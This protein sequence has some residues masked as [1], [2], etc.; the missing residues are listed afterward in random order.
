MDIL[1]YWAPSVSNLPFFCLF[2]LWK[3]SFW[4]QPFLYTSLP[5]LEKWSFNSCNRSSKVR[6]GSSSTE[7]LHLQVC[8]F[9][10][11]PHSGHMPLQFSWHVFLIGISSKRNSQIMSSR[12]N[13]FPSNE[14]ASTSIL[15]ISDEALANLASN[16]KSR[17]CSYC[18][19]HRTHC[20][21]T[22]PRIATFSKV[23]YPY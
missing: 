18:S 22:E 4:A 15:L 9:K 19:R 20:K 10:F 11:V 7:F 21:V 13:S 12:L 17:L 23:C 3:F 8:L 14:K 16:E 2:L 5:C 6:S 1:Q